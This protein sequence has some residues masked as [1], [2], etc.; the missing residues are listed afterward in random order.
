MQP[1]CDSCTISQMLAGRELGREEDQPPGKRIHER[2]HELRGPSHQRERASPLF[3]STS[4][5][6][7]LLLLPAP[8]CLCAPIGAFPGRDYASRAPPGR[9][10]ERR[11]LKFPRTSRLS[12][13]SAAARARAT[14]AEDAVDSTSATRVP[15]KSANICKICQFLPT[16]NPRCIGFAF[17]C[18]V[19]HDSLFCLPAKPVFLHCFLPFQLF[20]YAHLETSIHRCVN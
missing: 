5:R 7:P 12:L 16:Q 14:D 8:A 17:L 1:D 15:T 20:L 11:R 19:V 6:L 4:E 13:K 3:H 2:I 10:A 18:A 9:L